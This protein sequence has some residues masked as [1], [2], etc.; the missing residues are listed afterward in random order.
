MG[1]GGPTLMRG[2]GVENRS[3]GGHRRWCLDERHSVNQRTARIGGGVTKPRAARIV[4]DFPAPFDP[5]KP[6]T[7]SSSAVKLALSSTV[8]RPKRLVRPL[9]LS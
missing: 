6:V 9:S 7:L 1:V 5:R 8:L 3:Y 4:V 2:F